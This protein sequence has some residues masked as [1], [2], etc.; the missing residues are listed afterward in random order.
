LLRGTITQ[1]KK[2]QILGTEPGSDFLCPWSVLF[3]ETIDF[4]HYT[5]ETPVQRWPRNLPPI[6]VFRTLSNGRL[7]HEKLCWK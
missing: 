7:P 6:P 4:C 5:E 2:P 3:K 1:E